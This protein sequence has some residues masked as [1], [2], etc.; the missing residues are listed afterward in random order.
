MLSAK[1]TT[2][3]SVL[4]LYLT[5]CHQ[6]ASKEQKQK[7]RS[8]VPSAKDTLSG[9]INK[10]S[11]TLY[12]IYI[13]FDNGPLNGSDKINEAAQKEQVKFNVFVVGRHTLLKGATKKY[14]K[15][16]QE[17]FLIEIGNHSFSHAG[18]QYK[19]F[20]NNS[21]SAIQDFF[22]NQDVL[23]IKNKIL[24]M[25]GR[26]MWRLN[27]TAINDVK[28][29]K[30]VADSLFKYGY[31]IFGWD[32]EWL[33]DNI[34]GKPLQTADDMLSLIERRLKQHKTVRPDNLILLAH[35]EMFRKN[36][37]ESELRELIDKLKATGKY[38]F[39]HLSSY[40]D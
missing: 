35:D 29:G 39:Q 24:R 33:H 9:L 1:N 17:N 40:P 32:A 19:K 27:D 16:Y 7:D 18:N 37:E 30:A 4:L 12:S 5:A 22:K 38:R 34:S 14:Y 31:K 6:P 2:L 3:F 13:T 11:D 21:A 26:N 36:W 8:T 10:T 28:S 23:E 20:Y 15:M 25:P